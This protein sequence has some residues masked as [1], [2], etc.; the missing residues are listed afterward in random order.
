MTEAQARPTRESTVE[1]VSM[2]KSVIETPPG[3]SSR[4]VPVVLTLVATYLPGFKSGGPIR[5]ISS[6]VAALGRDIEFKLVTRDRDSGDERAYSGI[7]PNAW[8]RLGNADVFYASKRALTLSSLRRYLNEVPHDV[9]YLNSFFSV[10]FAIKPLLLRRLG[11]VRKGPVILAPRGQFAE[12]ALALKRTKKRLFLAIGKLLRLYD[13]ITW[14]ATSSHEMQ[15]IRRI[16]GPRVRIVSAA[17]PRVDVGNDPSVSDR[18]PKRP[19]ALRIALVGRIARMKNVRFAIECVSGLEGEVLFDIFGPMEDETYWAECQPLIHSMSP[20]ITVRYRGAI[21]YEDVIS[22]LG[23]YHLFFLPTMGENFGH[24]VVDALV[25]GCPVL[26][27]DRTPWKNLEEHGCGWDLSLGAPAAF[28]G[29]LRGLVAM[30]DVEFTA[31]SLNA[32]TFGLAQSSRE[33][34]LDQ[35]RELFLAFMP[36]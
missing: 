10:D 9:L 26:I 3:A 35:N 24:A 32:R 25:A 30:D 12:S 2:R 17:V 13:D 8:C 1:P 6:L 18:P 28:Q 22:K 20:N 5:S 16:M 4:R 29:A 36:S 23:E 27:S 31:L 7:V 19:G 21:P 15:D 11:A 34:V 33:D 14:Q